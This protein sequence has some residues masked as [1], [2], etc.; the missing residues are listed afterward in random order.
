[1]R[2]VVIVWM[3]AVFYVWVVLQA[4]RGCACGGD[5]VDGRGVCVWV[6][7]QAGGRDCACGG[8]C[9][10][11]RGVCVWVAGVADGG[12]CADDCDCVAGSGRFLRYG[13]GK[14]VEVHSCEFQ[15]VLQ[16]G[17]LFST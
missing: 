6:A 8:D 5:C 9:V 15:L 13:K 16:V 10:G 12:G 2:V 4:G 3:E 11:G 17:M 7:L 1:M 14:L